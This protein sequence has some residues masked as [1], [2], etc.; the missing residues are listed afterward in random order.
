MPARRLIPSHIGTDICHIPRI[1]KTLQSTTGPRFIHRVLTPEEIQQPKS[2][3]LLKPILDRT[4]DSQ[5][6]WRTAAQ[7]MAG[8]FAAKEAIRKAHPHRPTTFHSIIIRN[9]SLPPTGSVGRQPQ[10]EPASSEAL[11]IKASTASGPP[12]ALLK[13]S[14]EFDDIVVPISI[15]HDT[16]YATAACLGYVEERHLEA[17]TATYLGHD[18]PDPD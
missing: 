2:L 1:L 4:M 9:V 6:D 10:A 11:E 16:D 3:R 17:F 7:Y 14:E 18:I 5:S 8:R 15:S 13:G 12:K